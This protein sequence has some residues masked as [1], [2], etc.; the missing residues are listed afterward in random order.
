MIDKLYEYRFNIF[1]ITQLIILFGSLL[2]PHEFFDNILSPIL[3]LVNTLTG[4]L[5]IS[6]NKKLMWF[7]IGLFGISLIAFGSGMFQ[8]GSSSSDHLLIQLGIH[9]L[10]HA[11][12]T[13]Q[14]ILQIWNAKRV[15]N[16]V[17]IGLMSGYISLGFIAFFLFSTIELIEPGSFIAAIINDNPNGTIR[18]DSIMYYAYITLMTIGYGEIVPATPVAQKA[19][20]LTGLM[21]QFYLVIVTAIVVGKYIIH[22]KK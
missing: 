14:I 5:L 8:K 19:A 22:S 16:T 3:F 11:I 15:N 21:G 6:K 1:F 10:F 17:V 9:F 20:I 2:F 4:I 12:V 7:S 18:L 13:Y